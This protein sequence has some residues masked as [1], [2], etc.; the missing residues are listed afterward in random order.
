MMNI[1]IIGDYDQNRP[2]HVATHEALQHTAT[3]LSKKISIQWIPTK[4]LDNHDNLN[5]L[6]NFDCV[7]G[8]PG[9]PESSLGFINAIQFIREKSIPYLGT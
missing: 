9:D 5:P 3:F 7:W 2:S 1:G 6:N 8:A 4:P